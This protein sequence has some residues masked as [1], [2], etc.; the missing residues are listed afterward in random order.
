MTR[1]MLITQAN[2]GILTAGGPGVLTYR[3]KAR[4]LALEMESPFVVET[5]RGPMTGQPGD[6]LVTNHPDD[7]PGSDLWSISAARMAST[8]EPLEDPPT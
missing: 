4:I 7:D 3:K 6:Y 8:Y 1:T 2:R 5:D